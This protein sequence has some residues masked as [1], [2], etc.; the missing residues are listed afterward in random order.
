[1]LVPQLGKLC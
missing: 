1:M